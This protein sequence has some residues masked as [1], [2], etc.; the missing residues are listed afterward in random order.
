MCMMAGHNSNLGRQ[1][2]QTQFQVALLDDS[3]QEVPDRPHPH[4]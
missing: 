3:V 2:D 1:A 4:S